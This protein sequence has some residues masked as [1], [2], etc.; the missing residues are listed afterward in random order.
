MELTSLESGRVRCTCPRAAAALPQLSDSTI[1]IAT[2]LAAVN[3]PCRH[4]VIGYASGSF[5]QARLREVGR[6]RSEDD[7]QPFAVEDARPTPKLGTFSRRPFLDHGHSVRNR[8]APRWEQR[9]AQERRARPARGLARMSPERCPRGSVLADCPPHEDR[10][11]CRFEPGLPNVAP[12]WCSTSRRSRIEA[13]R[14]AL[15]GGAASGGRATR[16]T[17]NEHRS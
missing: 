2:G 15:R 6:H 14:W 17:L 4:R 11:Q 7:C 10:R 5:F 12:L 13:R 9:S 3:R 8:A 16:C 1:I